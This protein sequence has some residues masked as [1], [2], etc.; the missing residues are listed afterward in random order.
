MAL[1]TD[2]VLG[3]VVFFTW[4]TNPCL[5]DFKE[6]DLNDG[7]EFDLGTAPM[8]SDSESVI[9]CEKNVMFYVKNV[10]F[11]MKKM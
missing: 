5:A 9:Y 11:S 3:Q 6:G 7:D 1:T 4:E 10:C 2:I 8:A